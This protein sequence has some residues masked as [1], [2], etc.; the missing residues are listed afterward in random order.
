MANKRTR[1]I[2]REELNLIIDT[3]KKGFVTTSGTRVRPNIRI[4]CALIFQA[5]VGLRI[6]DIV[7]MRLSDIIYENGR[8]HFNGFIEEKT[9]KRRNFI[10]PME[11]YTFLQ[12]YALEN[13]IKT[14][15]RLFNITVRAVQKHL[16][17]VC[18]YLGIE[19]V[20]THSVR[21]YFGC[22]QYSDHHDIEL[23]RVLYQHSST[24][25]TSAYLSINPKQV[26]DALQKH[27]YLPI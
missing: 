9:K 10:I 21:K 23:L 1:A 15:S 3:I 25:V 26:E 19:G 2:D 4:A 27:T 16:Q 7:R 20:S 12:S 24:A 5:N 17:L 8:Y 18:D 6:G 11:V 22:S 13:G 14:Q